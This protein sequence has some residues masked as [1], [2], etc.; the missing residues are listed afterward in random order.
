[1]AEEAKKPERGGPAAFRLVHRGSAQA[2]TTW[3]PL[4][5][6]FRCD[7]SWIVKLELAGVS[8]EDI[9]ILAAAR[10]LTVTGVRRDTLDEKPLSHYLMEISY[11]RFERTIELPFDFDSR[12]LAV[13][14]RNGILVVR[15]HINR[16]E[17]ENLE[18]FDR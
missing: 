6:V 3:R 11:N 8:P 9:Q 10:K 12:H 15:I 16:E 17:R 5:D 14:Y 13:A 18:T 2:G 1:M 7:E 4:A